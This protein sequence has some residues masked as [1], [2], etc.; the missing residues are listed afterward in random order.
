MS[1]SHRATWDLYTAA[2]REP[3]AGGKRE[4]LAGSTSPSCQYTDPLASVE[5]RD[6]LVEYMIDFHRQVPGGHFVTTYFLDHHDRSIAK[7][8]MAA[9]DG[10]VLGEGVSYG[11][12][13]DDGKLA[14]MTGFFE[15]SDGA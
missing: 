8:N 3:D 15:S 14:R 4:I 10:A 11:E 1:T 12:Y 2:W 7:W 9:G 13:G 6:A 5:G